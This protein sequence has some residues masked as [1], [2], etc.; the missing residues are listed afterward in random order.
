M[1]N[2]PAR[3]SDLGSDNRAT[4]SSIEVFKVRSMFPEEA[5][6]LDSGFSRGCESEFIL[7]NYDSVPAF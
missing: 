4:R 2:P 7:C 6:D 1:R 5:L 3:R